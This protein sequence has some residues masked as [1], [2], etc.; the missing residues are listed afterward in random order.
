MGMC[1]DKSGRHKV[2]LCINFVF[3]GSFNFSFYF[4]YSVTNNPNIIYTVFFT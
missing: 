4:D 2:T 1:I 3:Y